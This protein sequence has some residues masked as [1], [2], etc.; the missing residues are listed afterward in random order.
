MLK[1]SIEIN[2]FN[3]D[4]ISWIDFRIFHVI[5]NI[6][7]SQNYI[8]LISKSV[9]KEKF[10]ALPGCWHKGRCMQY[11]Y[12]TIIWRFCAGFLIGDKESVINMINLY[13]KYFPIILK[14][15][16]KIIWEANIW[17]ILEL[18]YGLEI[19]WYLADH[20]DSII[21]LPKNYF[22]Q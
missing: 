4:Y 3:S 1:K 2:H 5:T 11:V 16:K 13:E 10:L 22:V 18:Y 14:E 19:D 21:A 15:S 17:A 9:L 20:N 7:E 6:S 12:N 8:K